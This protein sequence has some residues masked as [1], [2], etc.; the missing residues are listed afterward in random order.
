MHGTTKKHVGELFET[1]E[2]GALQPLPASR[3]PYYQEGRRKVSRDGHIEVKRSYYS[4]PPEYLGREVWVRWNSQMVRIL[5]HRM[6]QVAIHP[7]VEEG[8]FS[9]LGPH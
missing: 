9:T 7:R 5:N 4:A 2:R 8:K 1:V 3:F 6:E